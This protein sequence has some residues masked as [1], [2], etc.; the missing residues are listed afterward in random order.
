MFG[1]KEAEMEKS[2]GQK[3]LN[4]GEILK[5][6]RHSQRCPPTGISEKVLLDTPPPSPVV[7]LGTRL[8]SSGVWKM[9]EVPAGSEHQHLSTAARM[10]T[11]T[12]IHPPCMKT[13]KQ[14]K[15]RL[16]RK[17]YFFAPPCSSLPLPPPQFLPLVL[18]LFLFFPVL[19]CINLWFPIEGAGCIVVG[20][21]ARMQRDTHKTWR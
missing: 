7:T 16:E 5:E 1:Y 18:W 2:V 15:I 8:S 21:S 14:K 20:G 17:A 10:E 9:S 13:K 4:A 11:T 6:W 12:T 3:E 19:S